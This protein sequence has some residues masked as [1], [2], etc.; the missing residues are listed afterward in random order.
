MDERGEAA[1]RGEGLDGFNDFGFDFGVT[2]F[3]EVWGDGVQATGEKDAAEGG[4]CGAPAAAKL[5]PSRGG[6]P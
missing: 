3:L 2:D 4:G 5:Q 1:V 6:V